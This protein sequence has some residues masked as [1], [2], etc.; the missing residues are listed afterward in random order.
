[1]QHPTG[2]FR[3]PAINDYVPEKLKP[4]IFIFFLLIIQFSGGG[5]YLATLNETVGARSLLQE[6]V[7][8]AGFASMVGM[9]LVFTIM[10]RLKM[11][12]PTKIALMVCGTVLIACNVI[13]L[14]TN[15]IFI[16]VAISFIAGSFRMWATFECNS[17]IQLWIT[18]T[19]DM[20][21]FFSYVYLVVNGVILLGGATDM[22]VALLTNFQFV[23]WI[24]IGLLLLMMLL[25]MLLFNA[26]RIMPKFPLFGIDWLGAFMWGIT[27]LTINF[28][29]FYGEH[30][31]WWSS[32]EIQIAT[33]FLIIILGL[34]L[35][36]ASFIRHPFISLKTFKF[37]PLYH[38]LLLYLV[39][40]VFIAPSHLLEHIYFEEILG[41][42]VEQMMAVNILSWFGILAGALF[43]WRFFAIAKNSFKTTFFIGFSAVLTYEI[44]MYFLL[45]KNTPK[46]LFALPLFLRNFGYVTM[47][48]VLLSD[49]MK[50]PFPNFFQSLSV[51]SFMSAASGGAIGLAIL[52]RMLSVISTENFQNITESMDRVNT[53]LKNIHFNDLEHLIKMQTLLVSFKEIYGYLVI[54]GVLFWVFLIFYRYPYFP[55]NLLYPKEK[56]INKILQKDLE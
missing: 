26:N 10:L 1:M 32:K 19:R 12:I 34:N 16:L 51:Q 42:D 6:D 37:K 54:I 7:L 2:P 47:A 45:D 18:P 15:N 56:S 13:A 41:Y 43:T 36:R 22:Y 49:L 5:I 40:D 30:Y 31:D 50:I 52:H 20:P 38:S 48:I 11:R 23:N 14:K 39:I 44:I 55:K 21:V 33:M 8:M 46:E 24:V 53:N 27:L 3:I 4:W 35:Y 25:V 28:I 29:C 17:T 9:S